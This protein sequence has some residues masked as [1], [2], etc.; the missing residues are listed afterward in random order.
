IVGPLA[1]P[2]TAVAQPPSLA[3]GAVQPTSELIARSIAEAAARFRL[4]ASW[5]RA[6]L[7]AESVGAVRAVSPKGAMGLMQIMPATWSGLRARLHLG[8]DPFD[9]HDN[10]IAGA[11]YLRELHERYGSPGFLAAY[12]AGPARW[13]AYLATHRPLPAETRA[14]LAKLVP[15]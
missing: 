13:E 7:H 9:V 12:N 5:I 1:G 10:I 11:A 2:H 6:V 14:Y 8:A 4:P 3:R 15:T